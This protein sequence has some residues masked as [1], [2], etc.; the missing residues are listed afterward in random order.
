MG[1]VS[2][3][4]PD[5][6]SEKRSFRSV[7]FWVAAHQQDATLANLCSEALV[8]PPW[9]CFPQHDAKDGYF[10]HILLRVQARHE[11]RRGAARAPTSHGLNPRLRRVAKSA[12]SAAARP[13]RRGCR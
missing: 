6:A 13:S 5:M 11:R 8:V 3:L 1:A 12:S 2:D 7:H 10:G 9:R 4:P